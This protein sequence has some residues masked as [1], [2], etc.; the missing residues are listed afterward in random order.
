MVTNFLTLVS[1]SSPQQFYKPLFTI[2]ASS[3]DATIVTQLRIVTAIATYLPHFWTG[4]VANPAPAAEMFSIALMSDAGGGAGGKGKGKED[5]LRWGKTRL[6]QCVLTLELIAKVKEL[7]KAKKDP[8][9]VSRRYSATST[10][11]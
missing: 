5:E 2:A 11:V 8:A 9:S 7:S 4:D 3:K 1:A 6:G 10:L